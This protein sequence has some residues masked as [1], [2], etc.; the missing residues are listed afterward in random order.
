[1]KSG[2]LATG[3]IA[4][5]N[6]TLDLPGADAVYI[7]VDKLG[8]R[9]FYAPLLSEAFPGCWVQVIREGPEAC[10]Y[11]ILGA[12]RPVHVHFEP[13][14]DGSHL[15]VAL[16]SMAA[17]YLRGVCMRQ[18]NR[19]WLAQRA[20]N[21]ADSRLSRRC[22]AILRGDSQRPEGGWNRG[23]GCLAGEVG[24]GTQYSLPVTHCPLVAPPLFRS[25]RSLASCTRVDHAVA[26]DREFSLVCSH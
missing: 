18:F 15:N 4:L 23:A 19:Y 24:T 9:H 22:L 25:I 12:S 6:A 13:R 7:A 5:L 14:A 3:V 20:G 8:G 11:E 2:V 10:D 16:A 26:I 17:K 21:Q 1:M